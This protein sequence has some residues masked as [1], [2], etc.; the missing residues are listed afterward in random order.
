MLKHVENV[1]EF[2]QLI[3][4][5]LTVVDFYADWCGP[6]KMLAPIY[7][8]VA[9]E[10]QEINF[11]KVNVDHLF[12]IASRYRIASIPTILIFKEGKIVSSHVG[13][14]E[15]SQLVGLIKANI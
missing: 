11:L 8:D 1:Q 5:D 10:F 13:Y 4:N 9:K 7:E 3:A 12:E 15:K 14:L 6:C 2:D